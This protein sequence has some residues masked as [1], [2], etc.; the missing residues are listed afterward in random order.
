MSGG[1]YRFLLDKK[2]FEG[3]Y[4]IQ[5]KVD[6]MNMQG[7]ADVRKRRKRRKRRRR[8]RN[9]QVIAAAAIV[10]AALSAVLLW[11]SGQPGG[12]WSDKLRSAGEGEV[13]GLYWDMDGEELYSPHAI[14]M[15]LNSGEILYSRKEDEKIYPASLTKMMTAILTIEQIDSLEERLTVPESIFPQLYAEDASMAGFDPGEEV[16]CRDLLYGM[17]LP[18]G[19]ECCLTAAE[20]IAGSEEGF[21]EMM[22]RKAA[23]IGMEHTHFTNSTGLHQAEHYSTAEDLAALL[24]YA[25]QNPEFREIFT[26]RTHVTS[27]TNRHPDGLT[28][29]STMYES[30]DEVEIANGKILG[31]KTGY[32]PEAGLCLASLANIGG[33]EYI[34]VTAGARGSHDTEQ[35]HI[36]D[37][38]HLYSGIEG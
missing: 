8:R 33:T 16:S 12:G 5:R 13:S 4:F 21:A 24:R 30:M 29:W 37:A 38:V 15:E 11:V 7:D 35:Y 23:E 14:L 22:N 18:S 34:L 17:L 6:R 25:L 9:F 36:L 1:R 3:F 2:C 27:P 10:I 31:G 32:T 28:L 20:W 26:S 19:A